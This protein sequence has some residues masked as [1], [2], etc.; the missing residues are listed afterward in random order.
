MIND[1][2]IAI[3][4]IFDRRALEEGFS[5]YLYNSRGKKEKACIS[6]KAKGRK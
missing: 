3:Y 2:I 6:L 1:I 4:Y 5:I